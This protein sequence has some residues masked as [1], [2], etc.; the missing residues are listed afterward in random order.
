MAFEI[1][2]SST[3]GLVVF[4]VD[5]AGAYYAVHFAIIAFFGKRMFCLLKYEN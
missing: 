1:Y 3:A 5:S 2:Q 4:A